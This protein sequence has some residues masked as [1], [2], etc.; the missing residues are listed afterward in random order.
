MTSSY[1]ANPTLGYNATPTLGYNAKRF[2]LFVGPSQMIP[3]F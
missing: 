2:A 3:L 1:N